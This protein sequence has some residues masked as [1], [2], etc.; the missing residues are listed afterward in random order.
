MHYWDTA[1]GSG[2]EWYRSLM[3]GVDD[4]KVAQTFFLEKS[5][6]YVA[7]PKVPQRITAV[8]PNV[9]LLIFRKRFRE[10]TIDRAG[11]TFNRVPEMQTHLAIQY[12]VPVSLDTDLMD[13]YVTPRVD[14]YYQSKVH[15]F[16]PEL[17]P[18]NQSGF[19]LLHARLGYTFNQG[20]SQVALWGQNLTNQRYL[21]NSVPLVTSFGITQQFFGLTRTYG[22]EFSHNF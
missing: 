5:P 13:G 3:V 4:E 19:N 14:W 21:T 7:H 2:E 9:R 8:L 10:L 12:S 6:A 20:R 11:E 18:G 16:G 22:A 15:Y 17:I 1:F